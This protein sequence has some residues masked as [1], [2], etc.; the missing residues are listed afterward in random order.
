MSELGVVARALG[1]EVLFQTLIGSVR[2]AFA[3]SKYATRS[4]FQTLIGSVR[5]VLDQEIEEETQEFQTLIGSVRTARSA[6]ASRSRSSS[7]KPS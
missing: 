3:G 5:T 7:F 6:S 2:T 1:R 4:E